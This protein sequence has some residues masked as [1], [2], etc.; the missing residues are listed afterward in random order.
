MDIYSPK[1]LPRKHPDVTVF[2]DGNPKDQLAV[3][4][5]AGRRLRGMFFRDIP[6]LLIVPGNSVHAIGFTTPLEVAYLRKDGTIAAVKT[7]KPWTMH[8]PVQGAYAALEARMGT[9][10]QWNLTQDSRV[11][12]GCENP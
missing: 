5:T 6:A 4:G 10:A 2:V 9:F 1:T 8:L 3:A 7:L 12:F 11:E